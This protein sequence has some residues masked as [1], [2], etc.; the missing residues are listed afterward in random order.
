MDA[1]VHP[2]PGAPPPENPDRRR[3]AGSLYRGGGRGGGSGGWGQGGGC[4]E[5]R[6]R[7]GPPPRGTTENVHAV[8]GRAHTPPGAD[9]YAGYGI[10]GNQGKSCLWG[11]SAISGIL[12][13]KNR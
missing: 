4:T 13:H 10:T 6:R 5:P 12:G 7:P 8:C 3:N 2:P 9:H 11:Q 1:P